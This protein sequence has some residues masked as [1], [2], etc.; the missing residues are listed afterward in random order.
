MLKKAENCGDDMYKLE[1]VAIRYMGCAYLK[2]LFLLE[3]IRETC[4]KCADGSLG[5]LEL[6]HWTNLCLVIVATCAQVHS[7]A[8][9]QVLEMEKAYKTSA[10]VFRAVDKR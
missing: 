8:V 9:S 10:N 6:D 3:Q 2:R 7:D 4:V 1:P 5:M